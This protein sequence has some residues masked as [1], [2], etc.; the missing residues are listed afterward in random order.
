[1]AINMDAK[2]FDIDLDGSVE[3]NIDLVQLQMVLI[4]TKLLSLTI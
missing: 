4:G 2:D 3:S 1:M